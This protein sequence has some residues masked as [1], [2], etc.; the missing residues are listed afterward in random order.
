MEFPNFKNDQEMGE[1]FEANNV[2]PADLEIANGVTVSSDL[3][4]GVV[5]QVYVLVGPSTSAASTV[6]GERDPD[7]T[8][9][10]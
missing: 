4:V 7:L 8:P 2:D 1:W 6:E 10:H 9:V 5:G 3:T